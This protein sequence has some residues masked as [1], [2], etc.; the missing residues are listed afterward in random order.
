MTRRDLARFL[1]CGMLASG[2]QLAHGQDLGRLLEQAARDS[3]R[4]TF[5]P[6]GV[7]RMLTPPS[8]GEM[9]T[10][11]TADGWTLV[12]HRFRP[13]GGI[14]PGTLPV[15]LC[16]GLTYSAHFWD[17]EPSVSLAE[18]LSQQGHDVWAL[19]LRGSGQSQKW[20]FRMDR[21]PDA[22]VGGAIRRATRGQLAPTGFSTVDPRFANW[23]LDDHINYDLHAFVWL[24]K[25]KSGMPEV[26]WVGHSM[27]GIIALC[28]LA[29][30][31]N[32]GIARLA[33]IGSQVTMRD[34]QLVLPFFE[35]ML[36]A[37]QRQLVGTLQAEE[38]VAMTQSSVNNLFF[39][40]NHVSS[41]VYSELSMERVDL[42]S[43]GLLRQYLTLATEGE[44]HDD[45]RRFNYARALGNVQVP[46]L[47]ACG[48]LDRFAPPDVQSYIHERVGSAEKTLM[49]FGRRLGF[50]A[51]SGHDDALVGL[52]SRQQVYPLLEA[53]LRNEELNRGA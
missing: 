16:H 36:R 10:V 43:I 3:L 45:T 11:K 38:L 22:L 47:V 14:R 23:S 44:L 28:H 18:Y 39:N 9:V 7:E 34:A 35:E 17:I 51:D 46:L 26:A 19:D 4:Q 5:S 25:Q 49:V 6:Q 42:P 32:P 2:S 8:R 15:I 20:V 30:Y 53:W 40:V 52:T 27:G 1:G 31:R 13:P 21:A 33:V 29:K 24:V 41:K 37:R 50:A 48:A 12:A